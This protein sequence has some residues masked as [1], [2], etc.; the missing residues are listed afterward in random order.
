MT[1]TVSINAPAPAHIESPADYSLWSDPDFWN[2]CELLADL[3]LNSS[4]K[5][6][7]PSHCATSE[8]A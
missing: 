8:R 3:C 7:A 6:N 2:V 1:I 4:P 5:L